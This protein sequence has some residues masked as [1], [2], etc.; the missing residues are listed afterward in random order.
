MLVLIPLLTHAQAPAWKPD[1]PVELI[2][3][4]A[5]GGANDRIGRSLQR[6][7]QDGRVG[8]TINVLNKPGGGQSVAFAYLSGHQG[9]PHYLGLA[10][11]SWLTTVAAGRGTV[12]PRELSPVIKLLDEYQMYFVR[13]DSPIKNARD[14][15]ESLRKNP[16]SI[17]FGISTAAGNPI[18]ISVAE[19]ARLAGADPTKIKVVVFNSGTDTAIQV[20]GGHLDIGVQS[21]GS[22]MQLTQSGKLRFLGVAGPR[23]HGGV[24]ASVPT[25][26]EQGVDVTANVFY[27]IFGPKGLDTAQL[28]FWDDALASAMKSESVKKDL[29]INFWTVD[30]IGYR[31]L[32]A[33][34]EKELEG[35]RRTLT[36]LGMVK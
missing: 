27:T 28:A 14:I 32:P 15:V 12:T 5:P 3:G 10:S 11:S 19:I 9:N 36:A 24:L 21:P 2:I 6:L 8:T 17:S 34:L 25:M 1:K 30:T 18:H 31:D 22:A 16:A 23:R 33:F 20:A 29:D 35:Y 4:A 7:L 26:R 13:A